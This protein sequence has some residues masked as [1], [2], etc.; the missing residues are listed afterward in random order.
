MRQVL[1]WALAIVAGAG[2]LTTGAD[3][4]PASRGAAAPLPAGSGGEEMVQ[5]QVAVIERPTGDAYLNGGVWE[6]GDE[7]CVCLE[8]RPALEA[9]GFR[10]AQLGGILP[11]QLQG[12]LS[13]PRSCPSPRR[14]LV[15]ISTPQPLLLGS[16]RPS[17]GFQ[18]HREGQA[19]DVKLETGAQCVLLLTVRPAEAGRLRLQ[20]TPQ[21]RHGRA[22]IRPEAVRDANGAL[23]WQMEARQAEA[24]YP[25]LG[26]DLAVDA[27]GYVVIGTR[28]EKTDALGQ[29]FFLADEPGP[30]SQRLLVLR[31]ARTS[32]QALDEDLRKAPPLALQAAWAP[33][34]R[35][36]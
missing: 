24:A 10:V 3:Q 18:V 15:P 29:R 14:L 34:R 35:L 16:P 33:A 12:L 17:C 20:F 5:I 1:A 7:Q 25:D 28:L 13:S 4:R 36:P 23:R 9:N 22:E 8:R 11:A 26:W 32:G 27:A 19:E 31:C 2:C 21:V 6:L 30:R